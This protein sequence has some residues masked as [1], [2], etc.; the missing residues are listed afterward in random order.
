MTSPVFIYN[1]TKGKIWHIWG[2]QAL[3]SLHQEP[4]W[5]KDQ[6]P[7]RWRRR[8]IYVKWIQN[9]HHRMWHSSSTHSLELPST[10][11]CSRAHKWIPIR[12]YLHYAKWIQHGKNI[13]GECLA[14]LIHIWNWCPGEVTWNMTPNQM[15]H[16]QTPNVSHLRVW[17]CTVYVHIQKTNAHL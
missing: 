9:F 14:A 17:G 6:G 1:T 12:T 7:K 4:S 10:K 11:W 3:Q 8:R 5:L 13:W 2:L 15:W 16:N